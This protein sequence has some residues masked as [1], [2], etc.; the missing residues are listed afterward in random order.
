MYP[1]WCC[2]PYAKASSASTIERSQ[3]CKRSSAACSVA[4]NCAGRPDSR[5]TN[6]CTTLPAAQGCPSSTRNNAN[7]YSTEL[8]ARRATRSADFKGVGEGRQGEKIR[9]RTDHEPGHLAFL[10]IQP[11]LLQQV[12][13]DRSVEVGVNRGT[14]DMTIEVA[15]LPAAEDRVQMAEGLA[16]WEFGHEGP[17][18]LVEECEASHKHF[19]SPI[20]AINYRLHSMDRPY[21]AETFTH[22]NS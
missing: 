12:G 19:R 2:L 18:T 16:L 11:G 15:V 4:G 21:E 17:E 10:Q 6:T 20:V 8:P 1:A 5:S 3:P 9:R 14:G 22:A 13:L 7:W